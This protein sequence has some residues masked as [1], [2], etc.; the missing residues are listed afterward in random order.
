MAQVWTI[1][2]VALLAIVF[3]LAEWHD[4]KDKK[5]QQRRD[6]NYEKRNRGEE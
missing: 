4:R 2:F 1:I 3:G 6:E 5:R